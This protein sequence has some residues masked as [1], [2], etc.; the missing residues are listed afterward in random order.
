[1]ISKRHILAALG[2]TAREV[3]EEQQLS[4][5]EVAAVIPTARWKLRAIEAGWVDPD[6]KLLL[7]LCRALHVRPAEFVA[8]VRLLEQAGAGE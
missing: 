3:R 7:A 1:M 6:F 5:R 8:R 2:R 4:V